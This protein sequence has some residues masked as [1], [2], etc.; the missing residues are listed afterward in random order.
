MEL[1]K[2]E[3]VQIATAA[4]LDRPLVTNVQQSKCVT[5]LR[6]TGRRKMRPR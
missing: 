3:I 5:S 2:A 1:T 6:L 4:I